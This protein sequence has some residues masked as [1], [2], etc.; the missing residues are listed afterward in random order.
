MDARR[1]KSAMR[2][3]EAEAGISPPAAASKRRKTEGA[4]S[5]K[6]P[7]ES[8]APKQSARESPAPKKSSR[9]SLA[10]K[11]STR[12]SLAPKQS[13]RESL[14]PKQS[15]RE[16][17]A[18]KQSMSKHRPEI[19]EKTGSTAAGKK[20]ASRGGG[21][22]AVS[23]SGEVADYA[24][25]ALALIHHDISPDLPGPKQLQKLIETV[26]EAETDSVNRQYKDTKL[27][28][29]ATAFEEVA[30]EFMIAQER[31]TIRQMK[32]LPPRDPDSRVCKAAQEPMEA[33]PKNEL[34]AKEHARLTDALARF[35]EEA[36]EWERLVSAPPPAVGLRSAPANPEEISLD[37]RALLSDRGLLELGELTTWAQ[38][39]I[40]SGLDG[41]RQAIA[42]SEDRSDRAD[43]LHKRTM[44]K[45]SRQGR[46]PYAKHSNPKDIMRSVLA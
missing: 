27:D 22:R 36:K 24:P 32:K 12:D 37:D 21:A 6:A 9:E 25:A 23:S 19:E 3:P 26:L 28:F 18:P 7:R 39:H 45:V 1:R 2:P 31:E 42:D 41:V 20:E 34:K 14:A 29:V 16:S 11:Q 4:A 43:R 10:P 8:I 46:L 33:N 38:N 40:M 5:S 35:A 13:S 15:S 44:T 17:L 30:N